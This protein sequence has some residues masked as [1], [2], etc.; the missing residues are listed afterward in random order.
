MT[1]SR[2]KICKAPLQHARYVD[3]KAVFGEMCRSA[4]QGIVLVLV[5]PTQVGK[6]LVFEKVVAQI[7]EDTRGTRDG[8]IPFIHLQVESVSEGRVKGKWLDL[9]VLKALRH[10]VYMHIGELDERDHYAPSRGR[11]EGSLR[12]A[13][14]AALDSRET[15]RVA[16]DEAHLLTRTSNAK[17]RG[18]LLESLKS[19]AAINR[20]L[21]LSGG[22][23]LAYSGLFDSAHFA[24]RTLVYDFGGYENDPNDLEEWA[25][26]LKGFSAYLPLGVCWSCNQ[27]L[28][29]NSDD[30]QF[31]SNPTSGERDCVELV[32]AIS[33]GN[34]TSAHPA[35]FQTFFAAVLRTA[36]TKK[37]LR[38][39]K[40]LF[41]LKVDNSRALRT[42]S[43][44]FSTMLRSTQATGVRLIDVLTSPIG[45]AS[46]AGGMLVDRVDGRS[47]RKPHKSRSIIDECER[48]LSFE[49]AKPDWDNVPPLRELSRELGVG[50]GFLHYRFSP[51]IHLY[52]KRRSQEKNRQK[53]ARTQLMLKALQNDLL[54][55]FPSS[56]YPTQESLAYAV[57][58]KCS[59]GRRAARGA[60]K[61]A[62]SDR[63]A[64]DMPSRWK[65]HP[66]SEP[67]RL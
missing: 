17:L 62:L 2:L 56:R 34:L 20:T 25:R 60:V 1:S 61:L 59:V 12:V 67:A 31:E 43:P 8:I 47:N 41:D 13:V 57:M 10:P 7:Q 33:R 21:I 66:R 40:E 35:A 45:A 15:T 4:P 14:K 5:G 48:R 52:E 51:L 49:L 3:A 9:Q 19:V 38:F 32:D 24:G 65:D 50:L 29:T 18:D 30:W 16:L 46:V 58:E 23:E 27:E 22:Y 37:R 11:D 26:I 53:F 44:H 28:L 36:P 64:S 39:G 54:K 6:S 55:K 63:H 42:Q